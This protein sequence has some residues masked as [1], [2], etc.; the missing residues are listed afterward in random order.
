MYYNSAMRWLTV[1][2]PFKRRVSSSEGNTPHAAALKLFDCLAIPETVRLIDIFLCD[3][4]IYS[5][6]RRGPSVALLLWRPVCLLTWLPSRLIAGT[7]T[8]SITHMAH[9]VTTLARSPVFRLSLTL[10]V[11]HAH[12]HTHTH[13]HM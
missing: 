13:T 7:H 10:P 11:T 9:S 1:I 6:A 12:A 8:L 4:H 5:L 2:V 3:F